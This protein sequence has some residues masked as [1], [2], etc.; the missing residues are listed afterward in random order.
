MWEI[1][2]R[3]REN[4]HSIDGYNEL[5]SETSPDAAVNERLES[6][7]NNDKVKL[8]ALFYNFLDEWYS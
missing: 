7:R 3:T 6:K 2:S 8:F 5:V 4:H 1:C